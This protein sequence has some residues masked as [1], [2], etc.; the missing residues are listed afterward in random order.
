VPAEAAQLRALEQYSDTE[1]IQISSLIKPFGLQIESCQRLPGLTDRYHRRFRQPNW[2]RFRIWAQVF[3]K[4]FLNSA[5]R[6]FLPNR[7]TTREK[8]KMLFLWE[9]APLI[10]DPQAVFST[11]LR[12][13]A[14]GYLRLCFS[15]SAQNDLM[16]L[17]NAFR[18][19]NPSLERFKR[20][21]SDFGLG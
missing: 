14:A 13:A 11:R 19:M 4:W 9:E 16:H 17:L 18:L 2:M 12:M 5:D 7:A 8:I 10:T 20:G 6:Q 1:T 15:F 21:R 3:W